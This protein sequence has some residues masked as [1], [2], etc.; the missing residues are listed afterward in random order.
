MDDIDRLAFRRRLDTLAALRGSGTQLVSFYVPPGKPI[1]DATNKLAAELS[2]AGNIKSKQTRDAVSDALTT[3]ISRLKQWKTTPENGLAFFVGYTLDGAYVDETIEPPLAIT[4]FHYR[5]DSTFILEPLLD[6]VAPQ[7]AVGLVVIDQKECTIGILSGK[8]ITKLYHAE[9][10]VPRKH[11][12]G[13]ASQARMGRLHE[14]AIESWFKRM[15]EHVDECLRGVSVILLAG[16]GYTKVDFC[17]GGYLHYQVQAK[18]H[19]EYLDVGST[20]ESGLT[21][22]V[23]RAASILKETAS[24][25][26]QQLITH[27]F[28]LIATNGRVTYGKTTT[29]EALKEGRIDTLIL[30]E[31]LALKDVQELSEVASQTTT[32]V[33]LVSTDTSEGKQFRRAFG[34]YGAL[35]RY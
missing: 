29:I 6:M 11:H 20:D 35:L 8:R 1:S 21:E 9:S 27:L 7:E 25:Q 4:S 28:T 30:S 12:M 17:K 16:P 31:D 33:R 13:G 19:P 34:G 10:N 18:V 15:G 2:Q 24:A 32:K 26:E 22:M 5:C 14:Q 3:I 23:T